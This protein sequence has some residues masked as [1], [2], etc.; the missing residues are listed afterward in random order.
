MEVSLAGGTPIVLA[1]GQAPLSAPV[2]DP[3]G[4]SWGTGGTIERAPLD[5]GA[6]AMVTSA[7][8]ATALAI[9]GTEVY[10]ADGYDL[11]QAPLGGGPATTLATAAGA[12]VYAVAVDDAN[13]YFT[14]YSVVYEVS[15]AGGLPAVLASNQ[16]SP[17]SLAVN[18]T[19]VLWTDG[20]NWP[21]PPGGGGGQV[22]KL[23]PK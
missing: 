2:V 13:V 3:S 19:S 20:T 1:S 18:A 8:L 11:M 21:P 10:F 16:G 6:A 5:G 23:T 12:P 14:S 22:V 17:N 9:A 15:R 4:V 7:A